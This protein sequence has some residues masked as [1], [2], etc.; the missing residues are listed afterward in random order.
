MPATSCTVNPEE[1]GKRETAV[2]RNVDHLLI[3][4][5]SRTIHRLSSHNLR[6]MLYLDLCSSFLMLHWPLFA[7]VAQDMNRLI[8]SPC[9]G[10]P[11]RM[12]DADYSASSTL[13]A[14]RL[15]K[16]LVSSPNCPGSEKT[17]KLEKVIKQSRRTIC[18]T[19]PRGADEV[20]NRLD[21]R[22]KSP[23]PTHAWTEN[24]SLPR[25]PRHR[26]SAVCH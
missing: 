16:R 22:C 11:A 10:S 23:I 26:S 6:L 21:C 18:R 12:S 3:T 25:L 14:F 19:W 4:Q 9:P 5:L 7:K 2:K 17:R 13:I 1:P 20:M 8:S 15:C 24:H